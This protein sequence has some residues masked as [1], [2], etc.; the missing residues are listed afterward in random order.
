MAG[1]GA[2]GAATSRDFFESNPRR[3]PA[4]VRIRLGGRGGPPI[5]AS[6]LT[7]LGGLGRFATGGLAALAGLASSPRCG[8]P[9]PAVPYHF[10]LAHREGQGL[11]GCRGGEG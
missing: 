6:R 10:G 1:S 4:W 7:G 2:G 5:L 8:D 3:A 9:L 11:G